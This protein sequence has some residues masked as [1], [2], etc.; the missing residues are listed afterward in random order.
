[1]PGWPR[2][3]TRAQKGDTVIREGQWAVRAPQSVEGGQA[4]GAE[5]GE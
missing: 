4:K 1:M 2:V 3:G 5:P